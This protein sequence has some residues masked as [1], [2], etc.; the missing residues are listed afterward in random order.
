[1]SRK[2]GHRLSDK[3]MHKTKKSELH[4]DSNL[5]GMRS[6][7]PV[8]GVL[9]AGARRVRRPPVAARAIADYAIADR[10]MSESGR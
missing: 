9:G 10:S 4:P 1:M 3:D 6:S 2:S 7:W 8:P 5:I